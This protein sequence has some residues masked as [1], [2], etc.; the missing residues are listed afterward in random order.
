MKHHKTEGIILDLRSLN[1]KDKIAIFLTPDLGK[2]S[3]IIPSSKSIKSRFTFI[4]EKSNYLNIQL[5]KTKKNYLLTEFRLLNSFKEIKKSLPL[6]LSVEIALEIIN[7][8]T[9]QEEGSPELF[10]LLRAFLLTINKQKQSKVLLEA[11]KTKLLSQIGILENSPD[12]AI[13]Q[14]LNIFLQNNFPKILSDHKTNKSHLE[15]TQIHLD[16]QIYNYFGSQL[17]YQKLIYSS[18]TV[19][20]FDCK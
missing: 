5:Y 11:F 15:K 19:N 7:K 1:E 4:S 2:I 14:L 8:T 20:A 9:P 18:D 10:D 3:V 17:N 16:K 13:S 12:P 6:I